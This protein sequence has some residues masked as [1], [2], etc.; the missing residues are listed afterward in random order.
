MANPTIDTHL[1]FYK[2]TITLVVLSEGPISDQATLADIAYEVEQGD[3][4]G[5]WTSVSEQISVTKM[6][7]LCLE[8]D[9]D[10]GFFNIDDPTEIEEL[11]ECLEQPLPT[12]NT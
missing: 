10:P 5:A 12:D 6:R 9:T 4:S 2:T 8:Q 7:K 11:A 1:G 3:C